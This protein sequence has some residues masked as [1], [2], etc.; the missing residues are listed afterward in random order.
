VDEALVK[1]DTAKLATT[2][3]DPFVWVH[4]R[5]GALESREKWLENAGRGMALARQRGEQAEFDVTVTVHGDAAA[6]RTARVRLRM[7]GRSTETWLL[8]SRLFV[9][10]GGGWKLAAGQG[11]FLHEGPITDPKVYESYAGEYVVGPG[12]VLV[13]TPRDGGLHVRWPIGR[14]AYAFQVSPTELVS[15]PDRLRF[16]LGADGRATDV[17][18]IRDGAE[19]WRG[20]RRAP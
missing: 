4:S 20:P 2:V 12:R 16:T 10:Q 13:L 14:E 11:T 15:G 1:R 5:D 19:G 17:V 7:P 18:L 8:Q 9:K 3:A 6:L